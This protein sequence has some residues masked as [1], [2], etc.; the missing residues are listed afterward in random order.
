MHRFASLA[1]LAV[2]GASAIA[3]DGP[4]SA[5]SCGVVNV[6]VAHEGTPTGKMTNANGVDMYIAYPANKKTD[7]AIL[8]LTDIFGVQLVQNKLL[9]DS[10]AKAGY[11]VVEP[12]YFRGDPAPADLASPGGR[13]MSAWLVKHPVSDI[14]SIIA[15][16]VKHMR[17]N[18]GVKRIGTVGYC[19]GGKYVA[20]FLAKGKGVDAGFMAH[21]S[22]ME[23]KEIEAIASPLSIGAA[24]TDNAFPAPKRHDAEV[25]LKKLGI[26]YQISLYGSVNHGFGVRANVS[27]KRAKF[28]KEEA[29]L[30]AVRWFDTWVKQ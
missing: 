25:T 30:Q 24:E 10:F 26:P 29:Y 22:S 17:D 15:A 7:N 13:N 28:A 23:N 21:P 8:Y 5:C 12:D 19:F 20:R 16:T 9:A 4:N 18:L 1:F 11:L 14:D 6:D 2:W 3:L 27:D